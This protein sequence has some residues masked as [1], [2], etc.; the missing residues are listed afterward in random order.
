[1][2]NRWILLGSILGVLILALATGLSQAQGPEPPGEGIQP[3][4]VGVQALVGTAFTY[5]GYLKKDGNP[6]NGTCDF[7][8]S[9]WDAASSGSRV[10]STQTK[11][12]VQVS[13]GCFTIPDL[14]FGPLAFKGDARWLQI[15]VK[16]AG[17][18]NYI[19][20][21]PRQKLT[22]APYALALPGLWT[23][24]N[25]TSPNI[26][27]GYS[28][29][30]VS[31][32]AQGGTISGGGASG[33]HNRVTDHYGT[34]SG[35]YDNQAGSNNGIPT[36]SQY[37]TVGG[38]YS[39]TASGAS[40]TVSGGWD[41]EA[42]GNAATIG[43]G[44]GN[45]AS[46]AYSTIPG[47]RFAW[48]GHYGELAYASGRFATTG[49]AQTSLYVLRGTTTDDQWQEIF[50]GGRSGERITLS[51]NRTMIFDILI[52]GRSIA[53]KSGGYRFTGVIE[54]EGGTVRIV[55][56]LHKTLEEDDDDDWDARVT[57]DSTTLALKIEV[58]GDTG[59]N[60]RWVAVVRTVEVSW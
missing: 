32:D 46:G 6:Y 47:G 26:I 43:G 25:A 52:V 49:D 55:E 9:L 17:D 60:V 58:R 22:P 28:G 2:K 41:N 4:D 36:D 44:D 34:V 37:A 42:S 27:G 8:F 20:L 54:R 30:A 56:D 15:E 19:A 12:G 23:L 39:N 51:L 45:L 48:A 31:T 5:Q 21:S 33:G 24:Q 50:L 29:N 7:Q 57:A 35:G 3:Q 40:T 14:D 53:G 18:A 59:D 10:G 11:T 16:C 1:M 38:G 13:N